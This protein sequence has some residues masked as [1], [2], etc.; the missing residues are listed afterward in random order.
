MGMK[1]TEHSFMDAEDLAAIEKTLELFEAII[2]LVTYRKDHEAFEMIKA[3][4]AKTLKAGSK[5]F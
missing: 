1:T 3:H 5:K 4:V 2:F